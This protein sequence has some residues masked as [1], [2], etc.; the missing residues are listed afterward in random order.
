MGVGNFPFM[1]IL[2]TWQ[3]NIISYL[4][5]VVIFYQAYKLA[6]KNTKKDAAATVLLQLIGGITILI[7]SPL[8]SFHLPK[9]PKVYL[10]LLLASIFYALNNRLQTTARKHLDVSTF[11]ILNQLT[12]VFLII[13]GFVLFKEHQSVI[14]IAGAALIVAGNIIIHWKSGK[15][16]I[17]K[18]VII[19]LFSSLFASIAILISIGISKDFNLPFYIMLTFIIPATLIMISERIHIYE[20]INEYTLGDKKSYH[21]AGGAWGVAIMSSLRSYQYGSVSTIAPLQSVAVLLNVI[22]AYWLLN[23]NKKLSSKLIAALLII[24]GVCTQISRG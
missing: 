4:I 15:I 2:N 17:N 14:K 6:I 3:A 13:S 24:L 21:L 19:S 11:S 16:V 7:F 5:F 8:Y 18:Y 12:S 9:D 10:W 1:N 22:V 23:E 20:V